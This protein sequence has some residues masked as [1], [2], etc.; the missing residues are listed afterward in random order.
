MPPE[1]MPL[2]GGGKKMA[3]MAAGARGQVRVDGNRLLVLLNDQPACALERVATTTF[4]VVGLGAGCTV[5]FER[6]DGRPTSMALVLRGLPDDL[7]AAQLGYQQGPMIYARRVRSRS[8]EPDRRRALLQKLS[9]A[10]RSM[11]FPT[12]TRGRPRKSSVYS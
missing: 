9:S 6:G 10:P 8:R 2:F 1:V 7:Y 4:N 5:E 12:R 11:A 3:E